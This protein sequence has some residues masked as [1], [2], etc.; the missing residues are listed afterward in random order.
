MPMAGHSCSY[1]GAVCFLRRLPGVGARPGKGRGWAGVLRHYLPTVTNA[2]SFGNTLSAPAVRD[3]NG[4]SDN[5]AVGIVFSIATHPSIHPSLPTHIH[6]CAPRLRLLWSVVCCLLP[7]PS[8]HVRVIISIWR[9][10]NDLL[11]S[12]IIGRNLRL[13]AFR[14][15]QLQLYLQQLRLLPDAL[16]SQPVQLDAIL[17][18]RCPVC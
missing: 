9:M 13:C 10:H 5:N 15:Q 4:G 2:N 16:N 3:S 6:C 8:C 11:L 18:G 14:F 7:P 1:Y 12:I 17:C